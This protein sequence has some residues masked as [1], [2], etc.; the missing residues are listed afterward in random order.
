[1]CRNEQQWKC[2]SFQYSSFMLNLRFFIYLSLRYFIIYLSLRDLSLLIFKDESWGPYCIRLFLFD[3]KH[4]FTPKRETGCGLTGKGSWCSALL[5]L[6][7]ILCL[8]LSTSPVYGCFELIKLQLGRG[9]SL[10][11][12]LKWVPKVGGMFIFP[13]EN[14]RS[15]ETAN[16]PWQQQQKNS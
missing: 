16:F 4:S 6:V 13:F 8:S 1:M 12:A 3:L 11:T 5:Q 14:K 7:S 9:N 10:Q 2:L 15:T